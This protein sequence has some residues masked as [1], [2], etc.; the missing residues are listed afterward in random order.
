MK[1]YTQPT[2]TTS[3]ALV[4]AIRIEEDQDVI[5][6]QDL[7]VT[8]TLASSNAF[9]LGGNITANSKDITGVNYF[10]FKGLAPWA[11]GS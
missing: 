2:G 3:E 5:L 9:T 7:L 10:S 8:G 1:I 4:E 6:Y 11:A